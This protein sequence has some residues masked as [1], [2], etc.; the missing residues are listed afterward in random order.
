MS[1]YQPSLDYYVYAYLRP[2]GTPYYIGKGKGNRAF[3]KQH[4]VSVP[5]EDRIVFLEKN[6]TNVGSLALER[7][8]IRWYGRKDLGTGILRNLTD[9]G[10]GGNGLSYNHSE[11]SKQI[12]SKLKDGRY[13]GKDNPHFGKKHSEQTKREHSVRMKGKYTGNKNP[14]Y[15]KKR[16][17]LIARN[18][19][20]KR[21]VTNGNINK[22]VLLSEADLYLEQGYRIGRYK[23]F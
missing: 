1:I 2:D 9:G 4:I 7:F 3:H 14:M 23:S 15:G 17:D 21:W 19:L 13:L 18:M 22:L 20:P 11:K 5:S 6:L 12:M 8:Y 10:D 16:E